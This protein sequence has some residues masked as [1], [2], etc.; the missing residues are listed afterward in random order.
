MPKP[1]D[2]LSDDRLHQGLATGEFQGRDALIAE[3][4][5]RR[6]HE[7]RARRGR[8]KFGWL[9]AIAAALWLWM[10]LRLG[11]KSFLAPS[12]PPDISE[13]TSDVRFVPEEDIVAPKD[14]S[15]M[16]P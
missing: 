12:S 6:R 10:K 2:D 11:K 15:S 14:E 7:E 5:L 9:G 13:G 1:S 3:E 4:I 16:L 8:Y